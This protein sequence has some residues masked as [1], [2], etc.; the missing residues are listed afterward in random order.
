MQIVRYQ[1][2]VSMCASCNHAKQDCHV[3][4]FEQM[5]IIE[6]KKNVAIVR[7]DQFSRVKK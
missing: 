7:C 1:P 2:K 3:L 6:Q 4:K 5:M